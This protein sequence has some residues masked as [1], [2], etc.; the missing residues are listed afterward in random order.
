MILIMMWRDRWFSE[1]EILEQLQ[2]IGVCKK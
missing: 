2:E 1:K